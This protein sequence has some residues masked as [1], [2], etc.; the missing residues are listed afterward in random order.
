MTPRRILTSSVPP[1]LMMTLIIL[2]SARAVTSV[3]CDDHPAVNGCSNPF[4]GGEHEETFIPACSRHDVCY[5]CGS[6]YD[7]TRGE[8]D[9]AFLDDMLTAC[10]TTSTRR[11]K[12]MS[13]SDT[14]RLFFLGVDLFG[15][16]H[17]TYGDRERSYCERELD[18]P[19]LPEIETRK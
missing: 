10:L 7:I 13:C 15:H 6:L 14:A 3:T 8:C 16:L 11:R 19:C 5:G 1:T 12:R 17:Y 18:L 2:T 4:P 9:L